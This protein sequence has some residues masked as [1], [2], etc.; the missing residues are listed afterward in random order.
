MALTRW[1]GAACHAAR[2]RRAVRAPVLEWRMATSRSI[3]ALVAATATVLTAAA[4]AADPGGA[5]TAT[6]TTTATPGAGV[7]DD[8][9][10][11]GADE[12]PALDIEVIADGLEH[13]WEIAFL[14]GGGALVTERPGRIVHLETLEPGTAVRRVDASLGDVYARG[15]GG[16]MGI[17]VHPLP[18][19]AGPVQFTTCQAYAEGGRPVDVRLRAWELSPDAA[20]AQQVRDTVTGLPLNPSGRH[21]GCRLTFAPDRTLLVGTGDTAD[22]RLPQ[23]LTSL[24]GKVL[25]VD[26][27]GGPV[28]AGNPFVDAADPAQ[29]LVYSYGHRNVQGVAVRPGSAGFPNAEVGAQV[30]TAE[31]GPDRDDEINLLI[32]GGNHGWDP[33]RGGTVGGYDES[34]PMTDLDRFPDAVAALWST[35]APTEAFAGADFLAGPQWGALDG[36]LVVAELKAS[37]VRAFTLDEDGAVIET[38][39]LPETDG[40]FG[41]LR[42]ARLGPDGALYL[43]TDNGRDDKV[44]RVTPH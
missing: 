30:V 28:P 27:T 41:R 34:V 40:T 43:T 17:A 21:S 3:P 32:R 19:G 18:P 25:R 42:A 29:R 37:Q 33:S 14:D 26:A 5:P 15:E 22:G 9:T 44:L 20:S 31:H 1:A 38:W 11:S 6:A 2:H 39:I 8:A 24:G 16:L 13:P 35:G 23:D 36:A 4:C 7:T 10:V 12:V